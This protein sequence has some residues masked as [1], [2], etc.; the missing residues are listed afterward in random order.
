[1]EVGAASCINMRMEEMGMGDKSIRNRETKKKKA[2]AKATAKP[3]VSTIE[4]I[5]VKTPPPK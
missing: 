1:M 5:V 2:T 4:S 3:P